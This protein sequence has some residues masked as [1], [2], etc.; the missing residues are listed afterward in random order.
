LNADKIPLAPL[1]NSFQ[2]ERKGQL[3]GVLIASAS[4]KGAGVT[5]AGL[6]KNLTGQF[7]VVSTN[8]NLALANVKSKTM[9]SVI[10]TV[11]TIPSLIKNPV[12]TV[13]NLLGQLTATS[14][15]DNRGWVDQLTAAP[16]NVVVVRGSAGSGRI[17]LQEGLVRSDAFQASAH[18]DIALAPVL[19]NSTLKVPVTISL[20]RTLGDKLGLVKANAPTN[21]VYFSMPEFL[22]ITGP[23]GDPYPKTDKA[24]LVALAANAVGSA[25]T[26]SKAGNVLKDAAGLLTGEGVSKTNTTS[27]NQPTSFNPLDLF[28]KPK[29]K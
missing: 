9:K 15:K 1:V 21:Q 7:N 2:P 24:A 3:G 17:D 28:K 29:K 5:G 13:G 25:F 4:L 12:D 22:T 26:G 10:N 16:I 8:L 23:V 19:T 18:G 14:N 27:T 6:Q 20:N 11:M